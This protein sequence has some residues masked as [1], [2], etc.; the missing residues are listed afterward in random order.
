[1]TEEERLILHHR[2]QRIGAKRRV[3]GEPHVWNDEWE[4]Q[5]QAL[6]KRQYEE[7][8]ALGVSTGIKLFYCRGCRQPF[9]TT[10]AS[11]KFCSY[12]TCGEKMLKLKRRKDRWK[13]RQDTVCMECGRLFT[14][15]RN[16]AKYCSNACRQKAYRNSASGQSA[17]LP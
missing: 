9:Y 8:E 3:P 1:M 2:F 10:V 15:K 7:A 17:H 5:N 13:A 16:D 11:K 4:R 14:P 12:H 6:L